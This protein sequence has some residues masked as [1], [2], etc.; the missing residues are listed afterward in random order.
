M[1]KRQSPKVEANGHIKRNSISVVI[2]EMQIGA[3]RR[4]YF[5]AGIPRW[6]SGTESACQCR[7]CGLDP[8]FWR[9][10]EVGNGNSFR[11]SCLENPIERGAWTAT[12]HEVSKSGLWLSTL[13]YFFAIILTKWKKKNQ[14]T[15]TQTN[16]VKCK[17]DSCYVFTVV[18][19][20]TGRTARESNWR[21]F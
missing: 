21:D 2:L 5:L 8:W 11:Y 20:W 16:N 7:R 10:P 13:T 12:V 6:Q 18:E 1:Y 17:G 4:Y 3:S 15:K 9:S 19:I 14:K